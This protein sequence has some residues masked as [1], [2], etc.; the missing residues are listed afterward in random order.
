MPM[1]TQRRLG[2]P[3]KCPLNSA[4]SF[5][6]GH[7]TVCGYGVFFSMHDVVFIFWNDANWLL[8]QRNWLILTNTSMFA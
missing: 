8:V 3:W 6:G 7:A 2:K 1:D 4:L 5:A